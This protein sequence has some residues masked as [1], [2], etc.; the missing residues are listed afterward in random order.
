MIHQKL[1]E[2][3]DKLLITRQDNDILKIQLK[4]R[5]S[6][7]KHEQLGGSNLESKLMKMSIKIDQLKEE[8][9]KLEMDVSNVGVV[10]SKLTGLLQ[11]VKGY[12]IVG[13]I[14]YRIKSLF[15]DD[16]ESSEDFRECQEDDDDDI[17]WESL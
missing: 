11:Y 5:Q 1:K 8:L 4:E 13:E 17:V 12:T 16:M 2:T 6:I 9:N 15:V 3:K 7:L 10:K 14:R